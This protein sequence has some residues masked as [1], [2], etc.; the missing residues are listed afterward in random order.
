MQ[1]K[2]LEASQPVASDQGFKHQTPDLESSF[3]IGILGVRIWR[4]VADLKQCLYVHEAELVS[5]QYLTFMPEIGVIWC[6]R[7]VNK[8]LRLVLRST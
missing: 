6:W 7:L 5:A 8:K 2:V 4:V 1:L 3:V